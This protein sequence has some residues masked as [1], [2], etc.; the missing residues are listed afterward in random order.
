M[1]SIK[2]IN[3]GLDAIQ[4]L[5]EYIAKD[6]VGSEFFREY[7]ANREKQEIAASQQKEVLTSLAQSSSEVEAEVSGISDRASNN[8]LRLNE[9][10]G[11]I[12]SLHNTV[13]QIEADHKKY[14]EQFADLV[15]QT[16]RIS[17]QVDEIQNISEQTNLLSFNASIEAAHAGA[18]G[19]GFRII[20][21][22]VKQL[23]DSTKK[24]AERISENIGRLGKSISLLGSDTQNNSK[25][26]RGLSDQADKTLERFD[27][28]RKIN[29]ENNE[30]VNRIG[31]KVSSNIQN[32]NSLIEQ[33]QH[34]DDLNK[35]T[36]N[37]F[38]ECAS[39]NQMLFNDLYS[40]SYEVK[41]VLEDLKKSPDS[42]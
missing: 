17:K 4:S 25:N 19:A 10:Y 34:F 1:E 16:N 9:I 22:E 5:I 18:A 38:A 24:A 11:A 40:F 36:V 26:L 35:K 6:A 37:L 2:L 30:N 14:V 7:V 8:N 39:K 28:M 21:N 12:S 23:S 32:I 15:E 27:M 31:Q 13:A 20:A 33:I 42:Q 29:G 3:S 41:A